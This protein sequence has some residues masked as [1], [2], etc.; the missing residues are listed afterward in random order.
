[1]H[2]DEVHIGEGEPRAPERE[3]RGEDRRLQ[4][5]LARVERGV[6]IAADALYQV[7]S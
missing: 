1:V 7:E 6:R 3:R 2:L 4:E 5:L